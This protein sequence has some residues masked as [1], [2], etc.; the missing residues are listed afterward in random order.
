[1]EHDYERITNSVDHMIH[2]KYAVLNTK[3]FMGF[4]LIAIFLM[5]YLSSAATSISPKAVKE[6]DLNSVGTGRL[7]IEY[8][9]VSTG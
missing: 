7:V 2:S 4:F 6:S 5:V 1:M 9:N 3:L 8:V